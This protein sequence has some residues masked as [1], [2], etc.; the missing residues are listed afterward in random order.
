MLVLAQTSQPGIGD[1]A[2]VAIDVSLPSESTGVSSGT[3][4]VR[5]HTPRAGAA[6]Y[7]DGAPVIIW[8]LGGF[9]IKGINHGLPPVADDVICITFIYPG[10]ADPWSGRSSDGVYDYRGE[11]GIATL[12]DVILYASGE[13]RDADGKTIDEIVPVPVLHDNIGMIGAFGVRSLFSLFLILID[14]AADHADRRARE[15]EE[16]AHFP[17]GIFMDTDSLVDS[18]VARLRVFDSFEQ[19]VQSGAGRQPLSAG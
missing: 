15:P 13:L 10:G 16:L 1:R 11:A 17:E 7:P 8:V 5:I 2:L 6:R 9:E 3:L 19:L 4:A 12:R 18:F 14:T